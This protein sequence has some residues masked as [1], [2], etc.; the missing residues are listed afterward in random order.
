MERSRIDIINFIAP[1]ND[2]TISQFVQITNFIIQGF[3]QF[4]MRNGNCEKKFS[5]VVIIRISS[6]GGSLPLSLAAID[7]IEVLKSNVPGV[8][9]HNIGQV[10][11]AANML[12]LAADQRKATP[13]SSFLFHPPSESYPQNMLVQFKRNDASSIVN[14]LSSYIDFQAGYFYER[15]GCNPSTFNILSALNVE[16]TTVTANKAKELGIITEEPI[17]SSFPNWATIWDITC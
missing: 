13:Y 15:T 9:T 7:Q 5:K 17:V 2:H 8:V 3:D 11:S 1:I 10:A 16:D 6:A 4:S 12:F 14:N